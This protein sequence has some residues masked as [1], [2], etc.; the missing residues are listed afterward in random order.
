MCSNFPLSSSTMLQTDSIVWHKFGSLFF[1]IGKMG[2]GREHRIVQIAV[3][4]II[5]VTD[6]SFKTTP[7]VQNPEQHFSDKFYF[8]FQAAYHQISTRTLDSYANSLKQVA[9]F[10]IAA[11]MKKHSAVHFT[12]GCF[13]SICWQ[14]SFMGLL[15]WRKVFSM[16]HI[17]ARFLSFP[18]IR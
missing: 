4:L 17:P 5:F 13:L 10:I 3:F 8:K 11:A 2:K 7:K 15:P 6:C 14:K 9:I 18:Y 1:N 12:K 16:L